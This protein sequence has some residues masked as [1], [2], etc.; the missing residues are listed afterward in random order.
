MNPGGKMTWDMG[1]QFP[2]GKMMEGGGGQNESRGKMIWDMGK[3][4]KSLTEFQGAK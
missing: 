2:G 1:K 4:R 3:W